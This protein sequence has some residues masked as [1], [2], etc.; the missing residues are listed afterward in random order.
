MRQCRRP[1]SI[2]K[3]PAKKALRRNMKCDGAP[4]YVWDCVKIIIFFATKTTY[5]YCLKKSSRRIIFSRIMETY[6][7]PP[8]H[9]QRQRPVL[10][11]PRPPSPSF[12]GSPIRSP[13]T[14]STTSQGARPPWPPAVLLGRTG[15]DAIYTLFRVGFLPIFEH[16]VVF[17]I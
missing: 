4:K 3:P 5:T 15:K 14:P 11:W 7:E 10:R 12:C 6:Y 16:T 13:V 8:P 9:T 1:R 17:L 2:L